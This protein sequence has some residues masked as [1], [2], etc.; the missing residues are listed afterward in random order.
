MSLVRH[1]LR[2]TF[3]L[4]HNQRWDSDLVESHVA[5]LHEVIINSTYI[6]FIFHINRVIIIYLSF[7]PGGIKCHRYASPGT[8]VAYPLYL[9][10]RTVKC[11]NAFHLAES[12]GIYSS[13]LHFRH[14]WRP[15]F[16]NFMCI[17]GFYYRLRFRQLNSA[18]WYSRFTN[19]YAV[20]RTRRFLNVCMN[21]YLIACWSCSS[22]VVH[23]FLH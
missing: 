14:L 9:Y 18:E 12:P 7:C 15:S 20:Q 2:Q 19:C 16:G 10:E 1:F 13:K 22:Q 3:V 23:H 6:T 11:T 21:V 4:L 8:C 17:P 5:L